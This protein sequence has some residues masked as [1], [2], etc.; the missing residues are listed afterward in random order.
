MVRRGQLIAELEPRDAQLRLQQAEA[1]LAQARARVGLSPDGA[2][3]QVNIEQTGT[4]A[5][6]R[7]VLD[8]ARLKRDRSAKL[9]QQGVISRA[10]LDTVE[11]ALKVAESRYQDAI[12]E[13]RNRP[14]T[15]LATQV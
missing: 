12:E 3:E 5:Q 7:A 10:E 11:A 14:G 6:A 9:F 2:D 15:G 8:E 1:A 13:V 4:V